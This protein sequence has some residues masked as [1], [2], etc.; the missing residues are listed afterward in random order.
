MKTK[1]PLKQI[2]TQLII[3]FYSIW[4]Y[5]EISY[6]IMRERGDLMRWITNPIRTLLEG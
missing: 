6:E 2:L 3:L 4:I 5:D 1:T